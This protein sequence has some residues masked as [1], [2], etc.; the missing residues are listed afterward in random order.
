[1]YV[2][3]GLARFIRVVA[4]L[5]PVAVAMLVAASAVGAQA[6]PADQADSPQ[7]ALVGRV[8]V[9]AS[10]PV[11]VGDDDGD[12]CPVLG[13]PSTVTIRSADGSLELAEVATDADGEFAIQ[14][15]PGVYQVQA[16][17]TTSGVGALQ[18]LQVNVSPEGATRLTISVRAQ[19]R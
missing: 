19:G 16:P 17:S 8:V 1:M 13:Y 15:D 5:L 14:L 9:G 2:R 4:P 11:P 10:C 6:L 3:Q 18:S 7:A 12:T